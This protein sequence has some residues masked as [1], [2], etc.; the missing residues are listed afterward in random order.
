MQDDETIIETSDEIACP[1]CGH[2][3]FSVAILRTR[4]K[5]TLVRDEEMGVVIEDDH[6]EFE[7]DEEMR[8]EKP[9]LC[10][11]CGVW[12]SDNELLAAA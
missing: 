4:P 3:K 1:K 12:F 2:G 7:G 6:E 10:E 9:Y 11:G 8:G 5:A